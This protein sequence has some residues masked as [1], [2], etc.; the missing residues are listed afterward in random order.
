MF[1]RRDN[2]IILLAAVIIVLPLFTAA[3]P[4]PPN[5]FLERVRT[6]FAKPRSCKTAACLCS[7]TDESVASRLLSEYGAI[8]TAV[9]TVQ[10]PNRC[11]FE[12]EKQ[13][14]VFQDTVR[15]R[16]ER[17]SGVTI[18][19]QDEAMSA[20]LD[21]QADAVKAG[22]RI[23]PLDGAIAAKRS[24]SD[25]IL[26]WNSRYLKALVYWEKH[27]KITTEDAEAARNDMV[28]VQIRKVMYWENRGLNFGTNI[29]GS[30]FSS[31]APPGTSQHLSM[32]AFDV[33]QYSNR[34]VRAIMNRHGWFQ[35]VA[36]D[37]PHFT[38]LGVT[39]SDL[40]SRGLKS[41]TMGG[42]QFWV[43]AF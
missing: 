12:E 17:M 2:I 9:E 33:V 1:E 15:S 39:G 41:I 27:G 26:I 14:T 7:I 31:T 37:A 19:L 20:L 6:K 11:V 16:A 34:S 28:V 8:F 3:Q 42:Y 32:L 24:Y 22:L 4:A 13:V 36:N 38:Y 5:T 35:T 40:P 10:T 43:P 29:K 25:T 23:T 30:I 21:A 18:E